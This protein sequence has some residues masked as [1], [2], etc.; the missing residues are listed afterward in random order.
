LVVEHLVRPIH[1]TLR[2]I[3]RELLVPTAGPGEADFFT[4]CVMSQCVIYH[5][6]K[7]TVVRMYPE[8]RFDAAALQQLADRIARFSLAAIRHYAATDP[9]VVGAEQA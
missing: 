5:H 9:D 8:Q 3:I 7:E 2:A 6:A 4:A 1:D